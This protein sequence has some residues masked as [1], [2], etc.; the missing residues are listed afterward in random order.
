MLL[1]MKEANRLR[2]LQGYM[3]G[4][5]EIEG[6]SRILNRRAG[7]QRETLTEHFRSG[8]NAASGVLSLLQM[9]AQR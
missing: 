6:A 7:G 1:T 8:E 4:K 2:V 9:P 3:D 5:I